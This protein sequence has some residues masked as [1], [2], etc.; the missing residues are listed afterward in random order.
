MPHVSEKAFPFL[1]HLV[2][3]IQHALLL[4]LPV[5]EGADKSPQTEPV[6]LDQHEDKDT[7]VDGKHHD[8]IPDARFTCLSSRSW[9]R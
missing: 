7:Q 9:R 3:E 1:Q 2:V 4:S 5:E 6:S 8:V